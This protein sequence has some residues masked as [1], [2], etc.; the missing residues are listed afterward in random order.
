MANYYTSITPTYLPKDFLFNEAEKELMLCAG[1]W[2]DVIS[3]GTHY[4]YCDTN[5]NDLDLETIK[6]EIG[7]NEGEHEDEVKPIVLYKELVKRLSVED[8]EDYTYQITYIDII[9]NY[10]R[11]VNSDDFVQLGGANYCDKSRPDSSGGFALHITKDDY[12]HFS[13]YG[14]LMDLMNK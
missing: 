12:K 13:T 8:S 7:F 1:F 14:F 11:R 6:D 4:I 5:T 2:S 10:L 3:D 9:Q